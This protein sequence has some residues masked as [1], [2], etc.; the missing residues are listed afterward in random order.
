MMRSKATH[1]MRN[2]PPIEMSG[3]AAM[4]GGG[5]SASAPPSN[6]VITTVRTGGDSVSDLATLMKQWMKVQEEAAE[7]NTELKAKRKQSNAL[8]DVILRIMESNKIAAVNVIKG[9]VLHKVT[10]KPETITNSYLLKHCKEFFGG[11]ETRAKALVEYLEAQR[12]TTVRHDLRI[13]AVKGGGDSDT[14]SQ[15]S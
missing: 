9:T 3:F 14:L 7:L 11:D 5:G 15:R 13:Q 4:L 2:Q 10:E 6:A 1:T 8:R 12:A